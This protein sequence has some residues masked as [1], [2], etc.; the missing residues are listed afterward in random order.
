MSIGRAKFHRHG[1]ETIQHHTRA[2]ENAK[3]SEDAH[4]CDARQRAQAKRAEH[5][6]GGNGRP[7]D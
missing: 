1:Q 7:P 3:S 5:G 6:G 4:L 2:D